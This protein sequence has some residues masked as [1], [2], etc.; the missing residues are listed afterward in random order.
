MPPRRIHRG[1]TPALEKSSISLSIVVDLEIYYNGVS[2]AREISSQTTRRGYT[3]MYIYIYTVRSTLLAGNPVETRPFLSL[4]RVRSVF[5]WT[6]VIVFPK[7]G[8]SAS[9]PYTR[10][11]YN[12]I[13]GRV[14]F[15]WYGRYI[16]YFKR[17]AGYRATQ[18]FVRRPYFYT[19][20]RS[21]VSTFRS[22]A[23]DFYR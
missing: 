12:N 14:V 5:I 21:V 23:N 8:Y 6:R 20:R 19:V 11:L 18:T 22:K 13:Y 1:C 15:R 3:P 10:V 7:E 17:C 16:R 4:C 9:T 2:V